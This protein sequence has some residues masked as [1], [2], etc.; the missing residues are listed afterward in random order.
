MFPYMGADEINDS[1][2]PVELVS[3]TAKSAGTTITLNGKPKQR[4]IIMV[5][6]LSENPQWVSGSKLVS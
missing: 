3:F 1:P 6:K 5:L 2:L 4:S